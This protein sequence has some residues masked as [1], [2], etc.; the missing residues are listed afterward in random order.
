VVAEVA[1]ALGIHANAVRHH[2]A[3]LVAA[4]QV[5]AETEP[6]RGPGRPRRMFRATPRGRAGLEPPGPYEHLAMALLSAPAGQG[7]L[8]RAGQEVAASLP[9]GGRGDPVRG[10]A[11]ALAAEGFEPRLEADGDDVV[12][13][14]ERCPLAVAAA[15]DAAAVCSVHRGVADGLADRLG[16][17]VVIGL[18][19]HDPYE[20]G[21]RLRLRR[22]VRPRVP[23][24]P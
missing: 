22:T 1:A 12:L 14:L 19:P 21:C 16:G 6:A 5:V 9:V 15:A 2:L 13:V 8:R 7:E 3:R 20:A 17:V 18:E 4:D 23:C 24:L 10:L 11:A